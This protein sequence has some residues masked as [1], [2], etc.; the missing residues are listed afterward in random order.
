MEKDGPVASV[1]GESALSIWH[2]YSAFSG[3]A[4][5]SAW[6]RHGMAW[7]DFCLFW[8]GGG[9]SMIRGLEHLPRR[10]R[11]SNDSPVCGCEGGLM[12]LDGQGA[13]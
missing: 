10:L 7:L 11:I 12:A 6:E 2:G 8:R 1:R 3:M 4:A 9:G 13:E 5:F